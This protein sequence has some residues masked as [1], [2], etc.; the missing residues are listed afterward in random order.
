[1]EDNQLLIAHCCS[2]PAIRPESQFVPIP[3]SFDGDPHSEYCHDVWYG[4][5]R[6]VRLPDFEKNFEDILFI[7]TVMNVTDGHCMMT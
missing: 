3:P 7:L 1:M 4:K 6:M 2:Q 5:S